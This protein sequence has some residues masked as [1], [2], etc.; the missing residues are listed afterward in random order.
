MHVFHPLQLCSNVE[1]INS[2]HV[3][4]IPR[5]KQPRYQYKKKNSDYSAMCAVQTTDMEEIAR[6]LFGTTAGDL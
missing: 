6:Q 3:L 5:N 1:R 4:Y 2:A